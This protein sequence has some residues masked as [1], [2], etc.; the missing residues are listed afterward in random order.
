[1][2]GDAD[3]VTTEDTVGDRLPRPAGRETVS[4][5]AGLMEPVDVDEGNK[6]LLADDWPTG[7]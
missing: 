1:M 2:D 6:V 7:D 4:V 5:G 3:V